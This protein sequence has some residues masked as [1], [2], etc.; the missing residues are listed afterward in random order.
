MTQ[1]ILI[2][3]GTGSL[4][5][6]TREAISAIRETDIFV[7]F[8]KG[9]DTTEILTLRREIVRSARE[10]DDY[11]FETIL[12]A[13]RGPDAERNRAQYEHGVARWHGGRS[14]ALASLMSAEPEATYGLLVWGDPAFYD[15]MIRLVGGLPASLEVEFRVIPGISAIQALAAAH[16]IVLNAVGGPIHITTG[17]RLIAEYSPAL[18]TVVVMLDGSLQCAGLIAEHPDLFI[19][20]GA[21]LGSP[22]QVLVA[23]PLAEVLEELQELRARLR[24]EHGW[25]MDTYALTP[26]RKDPSCVN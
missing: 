7:S 21:Y 5:H 8:D 24:T 20:W 3:I 2:G 14:S 19:H 10:D 23:G 22:D 13:A 6:L 1:I 25:I 16:R 17:R 18:G 15:S 26:P 11:R 9:S 4:E 12:D